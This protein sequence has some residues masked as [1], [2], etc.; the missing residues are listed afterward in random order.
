MNFG[1]G[2]RLLR[3]VI[4]RL[5]KRM[6]YE[7]MMER[8]RHG[9]SRAVAYAAKH[10]SAYRA[11][12]KEAGLPVG[13]SDLGADLSRLPVLTKENTFGRFA[14]DM[15]S[16]DT[17]V[18]D[19][20]DVLTSSG[21]GGNVFGFRLTRRKQF[22]RSAF[23]IDLGLQHAFGVDDRPTLLVNCLPMGVTFRSRAVTVANVSVRE[24]MACAILRDLGPRFAQTIVCTDPLFVRRLLSHGETQGL[25][26]TA[27]NTSIILG[28]EMLV[29]AQRGYI[30]A[31]LGID[32]DRDK[33][34]M[35]ASSF[36]IGEL[37]LNL[38]FES[39]ET[40]ALRRAMVDSP[41][42]MRLIAGHI[43][44]GASPSVFCYNP[45]R[46]HVD[47][48]APDGEGYGE[49]CF[50]VSNPHAVI[51]LPRYATGD[52]GR[53]V[54]RGDHCQAAAM[55]GIS[56]CGLPVVVVCGRLRDRP[57]GVPSVE[58]IKE[59]LYSDYTLAD[60]LTGAFVIDFVDN[61]PRLRLQA[62]VEEQASCRVLCDQFMRLYR[63][64]IGL[65]LR[66]E[67]LALKDFPGAPP[68]DFERKFPYTQ[69]APSDR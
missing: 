42:V 43:V 46:C 60:Q 54:N 2:E 10:S 16:R 25:N 20:A 62:V 56:P 39:R 51:P 12:L 9:A 68:N 3:R 66:L 48:L 23:D 24:D 63:K 59:I 22:E 47:V 37:G 41:T 30:A 55:V 4:L 64:K 13:G 6:P 50:T 29:E 11:L 28:E 18:S 17:G 19:I 36:G 32:L 7:R 15:L 44:F 58:D 57:P 27:L 49:L 21:R 61:Q 69:A 26:W 45:L 67:V 35:V 33:V 38:L 52:Y 1:F 8:G 34:R 53:L 31:K 40:I 5:G 14:L 65:D